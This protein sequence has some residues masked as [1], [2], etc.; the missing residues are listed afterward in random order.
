M[1]APVLQWQLVSKNPDRSARFYRELFGWTISNQ[2]ALGYRQVDMSGGLWPAP[3]DAAS[4]VQLFVGV[5]DVE[6][7]VADAT[8]LG[9]HVIVPPTALPDGD[10]MAVLADPDGVTFG[11]M[12]DAR[13]HLPS[14]V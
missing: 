7:A 10:V 12:K 1:P 9:A 13:A 2:N 4:F 14:G 6:Q 11:V 3:P 8:G 5:P